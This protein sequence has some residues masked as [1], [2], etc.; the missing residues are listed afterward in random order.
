MPRQFFFLCLIALLAA[1]CRTAPSEVLPDTLWGPSITLGYASQNAA[2]AVLPGQE[3]MALWLEPD[4]GGSSFRAAWATE[5]V[6]TVDLPIEVTGQAQGLQVAP[7]ARDQA[8]AIWLDVDPADP[9]GGL[10]L[11]SALISPRLVLARATTALSESRVNQV[12]ILSHSDDSLAVVWSGGFLTEPSLYLRRI[13]PLGR[14]RL[15]VTLVADAQWP[16]LAHGL[17]G[18]RYLYWFR[19]TTGE[20][21]RALL[22][23]TGLADIMPLG[24]GLS[25]G[26]GDRLTGFYAAHDATHSYLI[27]NLARLNGDQEVWLSQSN[28]GAWSAAERL[29]LTLDA[30]AY[31]TGFNGGSANPARQGDQGLAWA[32]PLQGA[33]SSVVLAAQ[34]GTDLTLVYL[35]AGAIVGAQ[36]VSANL[37]YALI[38]PPVIVSDRQRHIY[39]TWAEPSAH[40]PARLRYIST[41]SITR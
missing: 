13:D 3:T 23:D 10:Q 2:P 14:P 41:R 31:T 16:A 30:G 28:G 19:H 8:H 39:L 12:A 18:T 1:G 34:A 4:E 7:A 22:M 38:G 17:D 35:Q 6:L 37:P 40:G 20:I 15:P 27:L 24:V 33:Y 11:W 9:G 32:R 36:R 25:F 21:H 5:P 29:G 26:A